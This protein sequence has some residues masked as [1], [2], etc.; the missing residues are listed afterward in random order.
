MRRAF[1]LRA[2][3]RCGSVV[4]AS[5]A[6][7]PSGLK[8]AIGEHDDGAGR[9]ERRRVRRLVSL[10]RERIRHENRRFPERA[11][12]SPSVDAPARVSSRSATAYASAMS[13]R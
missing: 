7:K 9:L 11:L 12:N 8:L 6:G 13:S 1:S 5:S 10:R 4:C 3:S 2:A